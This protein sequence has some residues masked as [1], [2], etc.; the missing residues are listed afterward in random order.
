MVVAF[1]YSEASSS[2]RIAV[3]GAVWAMSTSFFEPFLKVGYLLL[4]SRLDDAL[5][6]LVAEATALEETQIGAT[7]LVDQ[8]H[9]SAPQRPADPP[10]SRTA[11]WWG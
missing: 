5:W 7:T 6:T 11:H 8:R 1:K 9:A 10:P 2:A 3:S 4:P